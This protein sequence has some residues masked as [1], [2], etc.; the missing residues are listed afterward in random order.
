MKD[1][2]GHELAVS[3]Y[4][5]LIAPHHKRLIMAKITALGKGNA[6]H[7]EYHLKG[8]NT[9]MKKRQE[10]TQLVRVDGI[11]ATMYTLCNA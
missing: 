5:V 3:D 2:V 7:V 6:V 10:S 9:P 4:V 1:F 8:Y 11:D